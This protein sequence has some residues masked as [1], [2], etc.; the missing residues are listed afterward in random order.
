M[1][2]E[3]LL[4]VCAQWQ[5]NFKL[6]NLKSGEQLKIRASL[7]FNPLLEDMTDGVLSPQNVL[8]CLVNSLLLKFKFYFFD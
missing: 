5:C 4:P 2:F 7:K 6:Y 8:R 1:S 3:V